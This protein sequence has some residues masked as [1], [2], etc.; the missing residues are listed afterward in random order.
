V[1][2]ELRRWHWAPRSVHKNQRRITRVTTSLTEQLEREP[3][4]VELAA[5]LGLEE[6]DFAA[7]QTHA[8]PRQMVPLDEVTDNAHGDE[9]LTLMERLADP[10]ATRP[11]AAALS[12]EDRRTILRCLSCLPKTQA[13]VI[14]LHYLQSIPL[15]EVARTLAVTPSR[16]SQLHH[17]ALLRLR[18]AWERSH[19]Y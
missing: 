12:S 3:T 4:R 11:D 13:T 15:R 14:V 16:V 1:L 6:H 2:D 17:Q 5:A 9:N 7:F 18:G 19:A 10:L 8:T